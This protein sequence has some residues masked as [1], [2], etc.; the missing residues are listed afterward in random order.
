MEQEVEDF[1]K[2]LSN[3]DL[4]EYTHTRLHLPEALYFAKVEL[5]KRKLSPETMQ[6][7][8][9]QWHARIRAREEELR[10]IASEP[11]P[12][13][14]KAV[15]FFC[16]LYLAFPLLFFIPIWCK[17]Q[18]EGYEQKCKD[19]YIF[20]GAGLFLQIIM[21]LLKIPPWSWLLRLY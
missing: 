12:C 3:I 7:L 13:K 8:N 15:V 10:H 20:A 11:L 18:K 2:G 4:L 1:I 16:G 14:F 17:Y 9:N 5:A 21:I 19:I 6:E